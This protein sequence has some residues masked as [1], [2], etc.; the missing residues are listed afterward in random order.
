MDLEVTRQLPVAAVA[1]AGSGM[2]HSIQ[3]QLNAMN[4]NIPKRAWFVLLGESCLLLLW[5]IKSGLKHVH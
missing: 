4:F 1:A 2:K 5:G 3:R